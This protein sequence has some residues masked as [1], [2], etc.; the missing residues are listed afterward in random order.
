M[1]NTASLAANN[2]TVKRDEYNTGYIV[3][4]G[5]ARI[6]ELP[7]AFIGRNPQNLITK[8]DLLL[9]FSAAF[10]GVSPPIIRK[11]PAE[12]ARRAGGVYCKL[13]LWGAR[14]PEIV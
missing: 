7:D 9:Q 3:R 10:D 2:V 5:G 8:A 13:G 4:K 11:D 6:V 1:S 14:T 12:V